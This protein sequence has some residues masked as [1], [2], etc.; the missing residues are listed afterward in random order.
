MSRQFVFIFFLR[1][2]I[3]TLGRI[4]MKIL[5]ACMPMPPPP[6][7]KRGECQVYVHYQFICHMPIASTLFLT[8]VFH[9]KMQDT[10]QGYNM[11]KSNNLTWHFPINFFVT[12]TYVTIVRQCSSSKSWSTK[13]WHR[14]HTQKPTC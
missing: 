3:S 13:I 4:T 2:N 14:Y 8:L 9:I 1:T 11:I 10:W 6:P 12:P 5:E 7:K